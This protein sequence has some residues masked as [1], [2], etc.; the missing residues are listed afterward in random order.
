MWVNASV[1]CSHA[2]SLFCF[3]WLAACR[4]WIFV[5]SYQLVYF[6]LLTALILQMTGHDV[7]WLNRVIRKLLAVSEWIQWPEQSV[8]EVSDLHSVYVLRCDTVREGFGHTLHHC[9]LSS[10]SQL[11]RFRHTHTLNLQFY[12]YL[13]VLH[14]SSGSRA[15]RLRERERAIE[16]SDWVVQQELQNKLQYNTESCQLCSRTL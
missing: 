4:L 9:S 3:F 16:K 6:M 12:P 8:C 2:F 13:Y 10:P 7:R 5:Y 15:R 1:C 14:V 11:H